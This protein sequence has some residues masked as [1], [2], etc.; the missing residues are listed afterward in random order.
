ME[1]L[2]L[3]K[4]LHADWIPQMN[5]E[6]GESYFF[7][8]RTGESSD[9]HPNMKQ[10]RATERKQ[11]QLEL[12]TLSKHTSSNDFQLKREISRL[13]DISKDRRNR[14]E[15]LQESLTATQLVA[16]KRRFPDGGGDGPAGAKMSGW[17]D[18]ASG[19]GGSGSAGVGGIVVA[20]ARDSY[21]S[22]GLTH[23]LSYSSSNAFEWLL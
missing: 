9:E 23:G 4:K 18:G 20:R 1:R 3:A 11:R 17:Y 2:T 10:V 5:V 16:F 15:G 22:H 6:S 7:N 19:K 21:S 12:E 8:V 13:K 14:I